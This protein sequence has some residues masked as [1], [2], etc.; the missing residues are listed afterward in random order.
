[1]NAAV[2]YVAILLLVAPRGFPDGVPQTVVQLRVAPQCAVI[3]VQHFSRLTHPGVRSGVTKFRIVLR[4]STNGSASLMSTFRPVGALNAKVSYVTSI[5]EAG[6][7]ISQVTAESSS[8][9]E[10]AG[11]PANAHSSREGLAGE[12][13]WTYAVDPSVGE[14]SGGEPSITI[15]CR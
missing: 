8:T 5:A 2:K 10:L 15:A 6:S 13:A 9:A 1:M 11:F 4:A 7:R 3:G 12:V 14:V